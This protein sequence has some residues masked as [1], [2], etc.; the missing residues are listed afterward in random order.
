MAKATFGLDVPVL[1]TRLFWLQRVAGSSHTSALATV[2]DYQW[3]SEPERRQTPEANAA[4]A[5]HKD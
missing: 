5:T 4:G 3:P 2:G 1:T